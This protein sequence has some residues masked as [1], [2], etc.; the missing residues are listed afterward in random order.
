MEEPSVGF[1]SVGMV[2][3]VPI[4]GRATSPLW[5]VALATQAY[6]LNTT[7]NYVVVQRKEVGEARNQ[8]VEW[9]LE[10]NATYVMFID[11]DVI[12]PPFAAQRLGRALDFTSKDLYP[13]STTAVCCGVYCS[14]EELSTPVVYRKNGSGAS[15]DWK[16]GEIF[17]VESAGTGCMMIRT[18]V[19]KELEKPYFK[20]VEAYVKV[21]DGI[22]VQMMTDDIYFCSKVK[23]A[24]FTII[25]HGGVLCGH[26]D[27]KKDKIF[28]LPE[29]SYPVKAAKEAEEKRLKESATLEACESGATQSAP[30]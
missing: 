5:G 18:E 15:W 23:A 19:F 6:P 21:G 22:G 8:I 3:G 20:T 28:E 29:D 4:C 7:V 2:I 26:Y 12:I 1:H 27:V 10:H 14:K 11:D 25:A 30:I 13:D 16:V 24:G 9:A 17:E